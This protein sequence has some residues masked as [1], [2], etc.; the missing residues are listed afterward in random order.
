MKT[1]S[2][3]TTSLVLLAATAE[4]GEKLNYSVRVMKSDFAKASLYTSGKKIYGEI[5]TNEKWGSVFPM[6]NKIATMLNDEYFPIETELEFCTRRMTSLYEIIFS[7]NTIR[8]TKKKNGVETKK[9]RKAKTRTR[10]KCEEE[11]FRDGLL[12]QKTFLSR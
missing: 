3:I 1:I 11:D 4:A 12:F 9:T 8:V 6:D 5:K 7:G 2:V 10:W